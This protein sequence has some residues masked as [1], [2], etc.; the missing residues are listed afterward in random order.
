MSLASRCIGAHATVPTSSAIFFELSCA[1]LQPRPEVCGEVV[2]SAPRKMTGL[3]SS[4]LSTPLP[5]V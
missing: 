5:R 1:V 4:N 3:T 2:V